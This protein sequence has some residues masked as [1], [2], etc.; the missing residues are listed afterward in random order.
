MVARDRRTDAI[1]VEDYCE[2]MIFAM[3]RGD[4]DVG[5]QYRGN[6]KHLL[7]LLQQIF[8]WNQ[9]NGIPLTPRLHFV[10]Y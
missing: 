3:L 9:W 6:G 5:Y 4:E 1:A 8:P 7:P 2:K 10:G